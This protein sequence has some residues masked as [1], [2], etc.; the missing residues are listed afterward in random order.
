MNPQEMKILL[1]SLDD[2]AG[3]MRSLGLIP[4]IVDALDGLT[5]E[6]SRVATALE[7]KN[8]NNQSSE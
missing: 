5:N 1:E 4:A 6:V 2:M 7:E 3:S 8:E